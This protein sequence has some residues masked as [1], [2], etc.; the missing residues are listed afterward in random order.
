MRRLMLAGGL[1]AGLAGLAGAAIAEPKT[2]IEGVI[3]QQVDAFV[4]GDAV[5]AFRYASPVI[6]GIFGTPESFGR[7]VETGFPMIWKPADVQYL[8]VRT[9]GG[10]TI[11]RVLFKG[12]DGAIGLFD[13]EMTEGPDGWVINGVFP[14]AG[15]TTGA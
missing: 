12:A 6:Q 8:G 5:A 7:M 2:V 11:E 4:A 14:V 15:P 9:E 10:R 13:Y 3:Q 1:L